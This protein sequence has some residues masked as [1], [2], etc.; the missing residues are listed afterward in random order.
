VLDLDGL[1][2][3]ETQPDLADVPHQLVLRV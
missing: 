3:E 2:G 1:V